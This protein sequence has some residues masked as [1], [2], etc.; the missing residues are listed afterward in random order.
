MNANRFDRIVALI[1]EANASDPATVA[2]DGQTLPRALVYGRRMSAALDSFAPD[3]PE[4]LRIAALAQHIERWKIP[5]D[6]Y[7][8]D[9]IGYLTWRKE[10]QKLHAA[11]TGELMAQCGYGEGEI[12]RVA[13]L[14]KKERLKQDADVQA[15]EDVICLV[16]LEHEA[17][18]FIARHDDVKVRGIL[19]K[20]AAK[21]SAKGLAAAFALALEPRLARLLAETRVR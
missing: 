21:M 4:A 13:S 12:A 19:A 17:P 9:R 6:T 11:R 15:L 20:T 18:E 16:F 8:M 1:D 2:A 3:A 14:L 10:L 7:P 5:R